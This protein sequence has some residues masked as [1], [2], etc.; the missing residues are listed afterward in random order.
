MVDPLSTTASIIAVLQLSSEVV[1]YISGVS[2]AI[3]E[4]KRLRDEIRGCESVL[5]HLQDDVDGS[6][7]A[8]TWSETIKALEGPDAPLGRLQDALG[9][10][11]AKLEPKNGLEKAL[12][13][14]IWPFK[15]KEVDKIIATI[16]REKALLHVA[17]TNNCRKL[18][19]EIK[20]SSEDSNRLLAELHN[21][22]ANSSD[23]N[24]KQ[25]AHLNDGLTYIQHSQARLNRGEDDRERQT[26]LDWLTSVDYAS[27]QS[28]LISRRQAGTGQWLLGSAEFQGWLR[29]ENQ[30]LFCPG[31]PGAGKTML[32]AI[33]V[34]DLITRFSN[35]PTVGI[36]YIFFNFR[37]KDEQKADV[38]LASLLK[39]LARRQ[40]SLPGSVQALYNKHR[41]EK[42][43]PS[44]DEILGA[45]HNMCTKYSRIFIIVDALDECQISY[46]CRTRFLSEI[47]RLQ[48]NCRLNLF[49][50]SRLIPEIRDMFEGKS[51]LEIRASEEDIRRYLDGHMFQLPPFVLR[52][53]EL[54]EEINTEIV[55]STDGM[56]LLAQL[57]LESLVG[58]KSPT[59]LRKVLKS[60]PTGPGAYD[61]AYDATMERIEGQ[62]GDQEMLA[63]QVLSWIT[64]AKRPMTTLELQHALAV[65]SDDSEL[66]EDNLPE[67]EDMVSVCAGLVT[68][69]EESKIIRLVHYTTQQYF[70]QTQNRW[71]PDAE[72]DITTVCLTYLSF[73]VFE[74]GICCTDDEFEE[75]L[76][77]NPLY[78]YAAKTWGHH[79][80]KALVLGDNVTDPLTDSLTSFLRSESKVAASSQALLAMRLYPSDL[81]YSQRVPRYMK[82]LHMAAFFGILAATQTLIQQGNI[83]DVK[84]SYLQTPLLWA[85]KNG[86][87]AVV[88]LLLEAGAEKEAKD[89]QYD[90]TP[91]LWAAQ[92]GR[93]AVVKL[94]LE[95]GAEKEAKDNE[96]D[97]TPLLWAAQNGREAV[98]KLLLEAGAEK[99]AKDKYNRTSLSWA[100]KYGYQAVI[101]LLL[102]A[103]AEKEAKD[104]YNRTSLLWAA[105]NGHE[106]VVKLLLEAGAEKEAKDNEDDQTPL[107]W[108]AQY[109]YQAVVK[110][111]LE[112]GAE[113]EAKDKYNRTPLSWAAQ[114]GYQAIVKLLLEAGAE[115]EAKDKYNRTPL[116][117]AAQNG[118]EAVVKLLLEAGAEKEAKDKY[119]RTSL[120]WA[121]KNGHEAVVKLLL[122]AGAEKEAKDNEDDQ[123]P[124]SWAAQYGYQAVVKLLL[125]AGA[126]KEAKDKYNRTPLSWAAQYG[127]QAI[128]KLLLEAGAEKEAKDKYDQTPLSLAA[129]NGR[130]AVVKLLLEAGAEKEAKDN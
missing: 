93:E 118:R 18:I 5:E 103:G 120:L 57:H 68:V 36:A 27:Q 86:H 99:E 116:L 105:K 70:E 89:N 97:Q 108:A 76:R 17:L 43:R 45:L 104:K 23:E 30:T 74:S 49:A 48:A 50:T 41:A 91:L 69:D 13:S 125:E 65:E 128:V 32:T 20:K 126:E 31:I 61:R 63:K 123:T 129:Q 101:K 35:D 95:A 7:E 59:A 83:P 90:Q 72:T 39:Q 107:S 60:L 12:T 38:L 88:K 78:N 113:K 73:D 92:N 84:D 122:E 51:T 14:L 40:S 29:T 127:Y 77:S 71:F 26:I 33:V 55:R 56:F 75:R 8:K 46:D 82:G 53:P 22:I 111:L 67:V 94:L 25:F 2:G 9:I 10:V 96:D 115:K 109:G 47:F 54:Q 81:F 130:E 3:K 114:Y 11:K 112:A 119:N 80:R 64:C 100:A 66:D 110:L 15:E 58:R 62:V 4:R 21:A 19:Q 37:W 79:A 44:L 98:V 85:A 121:A 6:E 16:E 124:L 87:E 117:W 42:T 106:A 34:D 102:E 52:N 24:E 1:K 28:N